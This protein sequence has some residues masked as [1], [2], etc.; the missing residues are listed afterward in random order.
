MPKDEELNATRKINFNFINSILITTVFTRLILGMFS[1]TI[2]RKIHFN[3]K[4][5]I[6]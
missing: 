5:N 6:I 3:I 1:P 2:P 4:F